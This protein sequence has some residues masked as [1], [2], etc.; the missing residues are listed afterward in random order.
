MDRAS[1]KFAAR[2]LICAAALG[3]SELGAR[4]VEAVLVA[5]G[6]AVGAVALVSGPLR[7]AAR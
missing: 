6:R 5:D 4:A 3:H 7:T 2:I 1:R